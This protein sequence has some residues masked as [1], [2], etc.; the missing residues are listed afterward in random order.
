MSA[1]AL[2]SGLGLG[3]GLETSDLG[4]GLE[5]LGLETPGLVNITALLMFQQA[6]KE[7][8]LDLFI[9]STRKSVDCCSVPITSITASTF[10]YT[11]S[12]CATFTGITSGCRNADER[13]WLQCRPFNS[14]RV[15]HSERPSD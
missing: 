12:S 3:L 4:L 15:P 1:L 6:V 8:N 5:A 2:I 11:T 14:P 9:A 10:H 13:L 7:N